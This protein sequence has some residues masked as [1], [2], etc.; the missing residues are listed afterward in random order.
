MQIQAAVDAAEAVQGPV[1]VLVCNAGAAQPGLVHVLQMFGLH[2]G[3]QA[4]SLLENLRI[5][6]SLALMGCTVYLP[7]RELDVDG[8][9][10]LTSELFLKNCAAA[11]P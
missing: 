4:S 9:D 6:V 5:M 8:L 1:D 10:R 11:S 3:L 7:T 2:H